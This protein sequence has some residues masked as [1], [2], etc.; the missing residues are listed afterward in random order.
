MF[1]PPALKDNAGFPKP[2]SFVA[3]EIRNFRQRLLAWL[4]LIF[5]D[6]GFFRSLYL[7]L[8]ALPGGL[9]RSAQPSPKHL[10]RLHRKLGIKT[11]VNLRGADDSGRYALEAETCRELGITLIDHQGI[12]SRSAPEVDAVAATRALFDRI[13]YPAL[14]HCKSGADRAGFASALFRIFRSKASVQDALGELSARYGHLR[15][16]KT[17]ILD[18]FFHDYLATNAREPIGFEEWVATRYDREALKERFQT[19]GWQDFLVDKV[20]ERE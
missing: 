19:K 13:E 10:R 12:R 6:H 14:I 18:A 3:R 7:N 16:S 15:G 8:H 9:Y 20:L 2:D 11:V 1:R 4:D 17:G 5:V